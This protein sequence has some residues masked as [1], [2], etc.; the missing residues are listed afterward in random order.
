VQTRFKNTADRKTSGNKA[1]KS[2][3]ALALPPEI[4]SSGWKFSEIHRKAFKA[5]TEDPKAQRAFESLTAGKNAISA[6][7]LL[8]NL[9]LESKYFL[10]GHW[11]E[12]DRWQEKWEYLERAVKRLRGI[13]AKMQ[14]YLEPRNRGPIPLPTLAGMETEHEYV[15]SLGSNGRLKVI[16]GQLLE[17]ALEIEQDCEI[18]REWLRKMPR[19]D[20]RDIIE[21]ERLVRFMCFVKARTGKPHFEKVATL[22]NVV[23]GT[24]GSTNEISAD[25][26]RKLSKR[27]T[28]PFIKSQYAIQ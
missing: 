21:K 10:R 15:S 1:A 4:E 22:L 17:S 12:W 25:F 26:L 23:R 13:A 7:S 27:R 3:A 18:C 11:K 24:S 8:L 16:A 2:L 14:K 19:K 6:A 20:R 9:G 28:T 5:I